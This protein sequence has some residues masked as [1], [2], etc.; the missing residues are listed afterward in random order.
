MAPNA[1]ADYYALLRVPRDAT[2]D[3]IK[4]A[5]LAL[6][7]LLAARP[8][9]C[10]RR[11]AAVRQG[12]HHYL[13]L[14]LT[15][16]TAA[17]KRHHP[18]L[19]PGD[20][21]AEAAFKA[22]NEAYGVLSDPAERR[23]YDLTRGAVGG[24]AGAGGGAYDMGWSRRAR[25]AADAARRAGG[26]VGADAYA[27]Q[28]QQ[29]A[30][31]AEWARAA[32]EQARARSGPGGA[33]PGATG[34][35]GGKADDWFD[36]EEWNRMH[37]GPT[38]EERQRAAEARA[39]QAAQTGFSAFNDARRST[40]ANWEAR[41]AARDVF[42]ERGASE[43]AYYRAFAQRYRAKHSAAERSWPA[44]LAAWALVFGGVYVVAHKM[45]ER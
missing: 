43:T 6:G 31:A 9:A 29:H 42:A 45:Q 44:A 26:G 33:G 4:K 24:G 32:D 12:T 27:E 8:H 7:E 39:R 25:A 11:S 13:L 14:P 21:G 38:A 3:E 34:P 20:A 22:V 40:H 2:P 36:Y 10:G 23:T 16:C 28:E 37:F 18:D 17:A 19:N 41:R 5:Y 35:S 15:L 1:A 30:R